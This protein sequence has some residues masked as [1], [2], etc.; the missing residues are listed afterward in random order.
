MLR[1]DYFGSALICSLLFSLMGIG[2]YK[3]SHLELGLY[4]KLVA[5]FVGIALFVGL[6]TS[7][8]G[9]K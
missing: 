2:I 5:T 3:A 8:I 9:R 4:I 7:L 1:R 6:L